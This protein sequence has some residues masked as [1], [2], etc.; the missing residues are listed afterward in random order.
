M[1]AGTEFDEA[2]AAEEAKL[3]ELD[4]LSDAARAPYGAP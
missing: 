1:L 2:I 4:R 3:A